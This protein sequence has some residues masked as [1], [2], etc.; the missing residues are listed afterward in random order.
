MSGIHH[1]S[2]CGSLTHHAG[3]R[4]T[5]EA[6]P[7]LLRCTLRNAHGLPCGAL[8]RAGELV[9]HLADAHGLR[10]TA[11]AARENFTPATWHRGQERLHYRAPG[12]KAGT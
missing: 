10:V 1:C 5:P 12:R 11:E 3:T 6:S 9:E 8:K 4:N 2:R 7:D